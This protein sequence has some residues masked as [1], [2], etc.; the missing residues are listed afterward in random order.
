MRAD[1]AG[2]DGD[3]VDDNVHHLSQL[4]WALLDFC[5]LAA[6][7]RAMEERG[8]LSE[9]SEDVLLGEEL[10][11]VTAMEDNFEKKA[12]ALASTFGD[13][14]VHRYEGLPLS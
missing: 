6:V 12:I 4:P 5:E 9:Q 11:D 2:G 1:T 14:S 13:S 10:E 3:E 8:G 7:N